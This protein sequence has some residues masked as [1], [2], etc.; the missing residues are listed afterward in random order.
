[1]FFQISFC[2]KTHISEF[3]QDFLGFDGIVEAANL[4]KNLKSST[5]ASGFNLLEWELESQTNQPR[6]G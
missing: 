5:A 1:M 3:L 6:G 2:L 4:P